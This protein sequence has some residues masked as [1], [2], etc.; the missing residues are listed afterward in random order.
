MQ[1]WQWGGEQKHFVLGLAVIVAALAD[2]VIDLL[3]GT[4]GS[5]IVE[6]EGGMAGV[7]APWIKPFDITI[8]RLMGQMLV[9]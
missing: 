8:R 5:N 7:F 4:L 2:E 3:V 9:T 1:E 6:V